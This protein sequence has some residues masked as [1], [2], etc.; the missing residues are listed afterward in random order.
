MLP[1][2]PKLDFSDIV[3]N[4]ENRQ[5]WREENERIRQEKENQL[6]QK[7]ILRK[8]REDR[9][10]ERYQKRLEL[11]E[12]LRL[13]K[14]KNQL[15]SEAPKQTTLVTE[16]V[17]ETP[18]HS[19]IVQNPFKPMNPF[20]TN[21]SPTSYS[22]FQPT[23][24]PMSYSNYP[25]SASDSAYSSTDL[26]LQRQ[27]HSILK[28]RAY[29]NSV[30]DYR[31]KRVRFDDYSDDYSSE[32]EQ[33]PTRTIKPPQKRFKIEPFHEPEYLTEEPKTPAPTPSPSPPV[34][35]SVLSNLDGSFLSSYA[36][37]VITN[38]LW[39]GALF[40]VMLAR[41][42]L[43]QAYQ[44]HQESFRFNDT[45]VQTNP[46][47]SNDSTTTPSSHTT[48]SHHSSLPSYNPSTTGFTTTKYDL[49]K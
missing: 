31:T 35:T 27:P 2:V 4:K 18:T 26:A 34:A 32:E 9:R 41:G 49:L 33:M 37:P 6:Q 30:E 23:P 22:N 25:T 38:M 28:N 14:E 39:G 40:C 24:Q 16:P 3:A 5:R 45:P 48:P 13:E 17:Q 1:S 42:Y 21:P 15:A 11:Q 10:I 29:P 47:T 44:S 46:S 8:Q 20:V 19:E 36:K 43:S 12:A 7:E